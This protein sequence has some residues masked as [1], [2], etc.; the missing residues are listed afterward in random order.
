MKGTLQEKCW[1]SKTSD[2]MKWWL[3]AGDFSAT[4]W[5]RVKVTLEGWTSESTDICVYWNQIWPSEPKL[6]FD[7]F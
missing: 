1:L 3:A 4:Y 5:G 2:L 7:L 6:I